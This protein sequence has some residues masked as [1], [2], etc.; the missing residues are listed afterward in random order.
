MATNAPSNEIFMVSDPALVSM[1]NDWYEFAN[2]DH[3]WIKGRFR[4][5]RRGEQ[6]EWFSGKRF[7]E[8]GVG[9]GISMQQ[10]ESIPGVE[11]DGCD[12]NS[13]ALQ[14]SVPV[15]GRLFCMDVRQPPTYMLEAYDGIIL[16]DVIEHVK[17]DA[18]FLRDCLK[19]V[20]QGGLV[21]IHVPTLQSL[22]S[23]YDQEIGHYRRYTKSSLLNLVTELNIT[24]LKVA[25]WGFSMLPVA[26]LR[27]WVLKYTDKNIV[28][29]GFQPPLRGINVIFNFFLQ[30][31]NF[32]TG[33][34]LKGTSVFVIGKNRVKES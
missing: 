7:L 4:A 22:F 30:F 29:K 10:F 18:D 34:P 15:N 2:P 31:E 28:K 9:N 24:P 17:D 23:R 12:L 6:S 27:K 20:K 25:Y 14:N 1:S 8:I 5:L 26:W 19:F 3:F 11:I 16:L 33:S 13:Y 21:I 32:L